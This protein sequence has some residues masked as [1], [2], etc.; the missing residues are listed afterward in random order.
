LKKIGQYFVKIRAFE[1][2]NKVMDLRC[3]EI[4]VYVGRIVVNDLVHFVFACI[5]LTYV[6][7][8]TKHREV[9]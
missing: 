8:L 1:E 6:G 3:W 5:V 4:N 9:T 7:L 2:R